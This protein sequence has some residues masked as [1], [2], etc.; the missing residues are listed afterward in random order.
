MLS[1]NGLADRTDLKEGS[2][3]VLPATAVIA[4][5]QRA[6][7]PHSPFGT[8]TMATLKE[9]AKPS[10]APTAKQRCVPLRSINEQAEDPD[11]R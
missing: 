7:L 4:N 3:F 5:L 1:S 8:R 2:G 10:S 11:R 6:F 9:P